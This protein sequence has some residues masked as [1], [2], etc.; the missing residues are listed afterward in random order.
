M[1][2]DRTIRFG[3]L[4]LSLAVWA[5]PV[6]AQ[7][8]P[9]AKPVSL[10]D[11]VRLTLEKAPVIQ[12]AREDVSAQQ[13]V[14]RQARG[15]FDGEVRLG[16]L[17]EHREDSIENTAYFEPERVKRG[18]AKGLNQAFHVVADNLAEQRRQG[19]GDLP[20]CPADGT[21]SSY[22][23]TLPGSVLPVPLCR[24]ASL[25]LGAQSYDNIANGGDFNTL[26]Y[27]Q[28][29]SF[30]PMS[31]YDLQSELASVFQVQVSTQVLDMRE[32]SN[33]LL[34]TLQVYARIVEVR[35]GLAYTRLGVLPDFVASNSVSIFGQYSKPFRNGNVFQFKATFDGRGTLFRGKPIDPTFGGSSTP[36]S[37]GNRLEAFWV[38]PLRRG[39]GAD[40]VQ[41]AERA[42]AKNVDASRF[43]FQQTS[44]DQALATANAYFGLIAAEES[45]ALTRQSLD[46]QR[47]TLETTIKLVGAGE[48]ASADL[49]RARART[50][51]V[52]S[53]VATARLA[54]VAAQSTLADAMGVP[55]SEMST[56]SAADAF[57]VKPVDLDV[58]ALS[59]EASSRRADLKAASALRDTS[60]IL[61]AAARADTRSRF[62]LS[63]SG[64]MAQR[65]YGSTFESLPSELANLPARDAY[66]TYYNPTGLG[67]A[68]QKRWEPVASITGTIELP[69]R[70][71]RRLGR[72]D[73]ATASVRESE[74]RLGDLGR[75]IQ[76]AVPQFADN[77]RRAR[78]EWEQR[79]D[80]VIQ[81]EATWDAA[82]RLRGAG[83][84]T[85]IDTLLTEQQLTQARLQLVQAK[86]SYASAVAR[87]RRETGTLVV[88]S[89]W[90]QGQPNLAGIV[91]AR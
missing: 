63:F 43:T 70:N 45:L 42:A 48:V 30:D 18:F 10:T 47:R 67:R 57:P 82:Q 59:T 26:L 7:S 68:F 8:P 73:Q 56:L 86:R 33:E 34:D 64:G 78:A 91:A 11:A 72:L 1:A 22:Y 38:Q 71:N 83:E 65:Y 51:E 80:A 12:L 60:R 87:F 24:P 58:D 5:A 25:S 89:D 28:P 20:L 2:D 9:A 55:Y 54:V 4:A 16:P 44:A 90:T 62:D 46:T 49:A 66:L 17:F 3:V 75:S 13:A 37:W 79:Q 53:D 35:A 36:N 27:R 6:A 77:L 39:H 19:R 32:R 52:E 88:F 14:V 23:V 69:F 50:S 41:A 31:T 29:L 76:N 84:M 15:A 21:Y 85:L 40:T 61:L 81:Y 74:I